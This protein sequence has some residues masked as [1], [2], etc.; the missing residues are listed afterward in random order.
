MNNQKEKIT[1]RTSIGS[2]IQ[3]PYKD[4]RDP[5]TGWRHNAVQW[6]RDVTT[7]QEYVF[8]GFRP[9][10]IYH[11]EYLPKGKDT[12]SFYD[13]K[14]LIIFLKPA[15]A[16][17]TYYGYNLHFVPMKLREEVFNQFQYNH[18]GMVIDESTW[19]GMRIIQRFY[20]FILRKYLYNRI[21]G[22]IYPIPMRLY[23]M[24]NVKYFPSEHFY[25]MS[26]DQIFRLAVLHWR[27]NK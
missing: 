11:Y 24:E 25:K 15:D 17:L 27:K 9:G 2:L 10:Y 3:N 5:S 6:L 1:N 7:T 16:G 4:L 8:R 22:K 13:K 18:N 12:L 26:S 21:R 14:P 19:R 23:D 20:P